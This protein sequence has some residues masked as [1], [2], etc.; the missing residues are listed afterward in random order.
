MIFSLKPDRWKRL[1]ASLLVATAMANLGMI[2]RAR[3]FMFRGYADFTAFYT[4]GKLLSRGQG[5]RLYETKLQW[6]VQ[7]EFAPAVAI[8]DG[9][10]PYIRPPFQALLFLPL[11]Y[12]SY[13]QAFFV[14]MG[15]KLGLL[16]CIAFLLTRDSPGPRLLSPW[17]SWGLSLSVAPIAMD[18]LQGQDAILFLLVCLLAFASMARGAD[19]MAGVWMGLA[20]FKFHLILPVILVV[21]LRRQGR[22]LLGF[23]TTAVGLLLI[24]AA[25]VG[26]ETLLHYPRYLWE[27]SHSR[28][29][30]VFQAVDMDNLRGLL[31]RMSQS[32]EWRRVAEWVYVPLAV[33]G[34][35]GAWRVWSVHRNNPILF[36]GGFCFC[37]VVALLVSFYFSGYDLMLLLLPLLLL[38]RTVLRSEQIPK[39]VKWTFVTTLGFILL[40]PVFWTWVIYAYLGHLDGP[41]MLLFA[42]ALAYCIIVWRKNTPAL[43]T[44][45]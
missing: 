9:A 23:L 6:E 12:L 28:G 16:L 18:L 15:I 10:L 13:R 42:A 33:L 40:V 3:M 22:I 20:L 7:R 45:A 36:V 5:S 26:W 43:S 17:T 1:L 2:W 19:L 35:I 44:A 29:T 24:S 30:G 38:S 14:W 31:L 11:A 4:A 34:V 25:L 32:P 27:I 37:L 41:A 21:A 8:R 39:Y